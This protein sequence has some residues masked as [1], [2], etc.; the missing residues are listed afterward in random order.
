MDRLRAI[1]SATGVSVEYLAGLDEDMLSKWA[2]LVRR[3]RT[4]VAPTGRKPRPRNV[5]ARAIPFPFS[6]MK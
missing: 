5:I 2:A 3:P 6:L 1:S 4:E